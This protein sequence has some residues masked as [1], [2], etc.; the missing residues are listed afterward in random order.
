MKTLKDF[1]SEVQFRI[2]E[3][4]QRGLKGVFDGERYENFDTQKAIE[5]VNYN[6]EL[7]GYKPPMVLVAENPL[8]AQLLFNYVRLII[9]D[10][11]QLDSQLDSKLYSRLDSQLYSQL[12]S[13]L[14]SQLYSQLGSQL[15]SKLGSKL[16]SKLDSQLGSQF[17]SQLGSKL[18]SQL[19]SQLYSQ[20]YSQLD[21]Q[22]G[23]Q[24]YSQLY[25]QLDSQLDSQ[26]GELYKRHYDYLFTLNVYSDCYY[27][28]FEFMRKEL[29][30]NLTKDV[31]IIFQKVFKLQRDSGIYNAIFS[32]ALCIVSKYPKKVNRNSSNDLH[33][34]NGGAVEWNC[35]SKETKLDC[36]CV[37]GREVE[38]ELIEKP[39]T[40][41]DLIN[42][43][44]ED[45]KAAMITI[46]KE[47]NGDKGLLDFLDA[48]VVDKKEIQHF[49]GYT[50]T[51]RLYKTKESYEILQDRFGNMGQP[52]CWSE[53]VCPSTNT[54]YLIENSADF[55]DAEE[56][57]KFLRPSFVPQKLLYR[58]ESFAN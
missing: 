51:V 38:K 25:S 47:R 46:V 12:G 45:K 18:D 19:G 29:K 1:T 27:N 32:E 14:Y 15:G 2:P 48:I 4:I 9:K 35:F 5:A 3:Y 54:T 34:V 41:D 21:S 43:E 8:E 37:N 20:L 16:Y 44:N 58:W 52:Y 40:K 31:D 23:S 30:I 33:N 11:S 13:K 22:L 7:C 49:E 42:E 55:T 17:Y 39:F 36:F 57:L 6:Y 26:R 10:K 56:A 53:I 28:W 24:L 50:E